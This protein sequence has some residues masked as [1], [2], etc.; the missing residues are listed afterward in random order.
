LLGNE[1]SCLPE[2]ALGALQGVFANIDGPHLLPKAAHF[3]QEDV[4][5]EIL[6]QIERWL[7]E[8]GLSI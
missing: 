7:I 4:A 8:Q 2:A 3:L 5:P 1:R 6:D